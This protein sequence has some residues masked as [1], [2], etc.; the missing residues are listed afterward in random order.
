[1]VQVGQYFRVTHHTLY[2]GTLPAPGVDFLGMITKL[3]FT[4]DDDI[5]QPYRLDLEVSER[6]VN[7][8]F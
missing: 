6:V 1:M 5:D 4:L 3:T 2:Q 8:T 7:G